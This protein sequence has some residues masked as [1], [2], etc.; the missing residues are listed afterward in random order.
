MHVDGSGSGSGSG[1]A[2]PLSRGFRY[3]ALF[4]RG[5]RGIVERQQVVDCGGFV[6]L[7]QLSEHLLQR[8]EW[9][10]AKGA[11]SQD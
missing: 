6:P 8:G 11:A 10:D 5:R 4:S 2:E 9:V 3:P 1:S 7:R